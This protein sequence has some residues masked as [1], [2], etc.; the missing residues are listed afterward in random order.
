MQ[1]NRDSK[2]PSLS[3]HSTATPVAKP[4]PL[5][6]PLRGLLDLLMQVSETTGDMQ[7]EVLSRKGLRIASL[8]VSQKQ[9]MFGVSI[10][11]LFFV[12]RL[13]DQIAPAIAAPL[14]LFQ[15]QQ[16]LQPGREEFPRPEF[17][18][19]ERTA[20]LALTARGL[21]GLAGRL[22][23]GPVRVKRSPPSTTI[24]WSA[25]LRFSPMEL[26]LDRP[27]TA[28]LYEDVTYDLF[29]Q[30]PPGTTDSW[31]FVQ[32]NPGQLWP[33]ATVNTGIKSVQDANVACQIA[34][35][36][37]QVLQR[38]SVVLTKERQHSVCITGDGSL[39][40]LVANLN[41]AVLLTL[42]A[43]QLGRVLRIAQQCCSKTTEPESVRTPIT[44]SQPP[45]EPVPA[46]A[47]VSAELTPHPETRVADSEQPSHE[48][49]EQ[50]ADVDQ[51]H[52]EAAHA[53]ETESEQSP[54][55][56][57]RNLQVKADDRTLIKDLTL[58]IPARG[59]YALMGPGGAGKSTLLGVLGGGIAGLQQEGELLYLGQTLTTSHHPV[60]LGQRLDAQE[61]TLIEYVLQRSGPHSVREELHAAE[62]L[63]DSGL[64]RLRA[65]LQRSVRSLGLSASQAW[66]LS[67]LRAL[68]TN[69]ALLCVDEPTAGMENEDAQ[70]ILDLIQHLAAQRAILFVSHNQAHAKSIAQTIALMA[71]ARLHGVLPCAEFFGESAN[72]I[73]REYVRTGGCHVPS[74]DAPLEHIDPDYLAPP[75]ALPVPSPEPEVVQTPP[76]TII[77]WQQDQ[78]VLMLRD[79][80]LTM[81]E[82]CRLSQVNLDLGANG[83]YQLVCPDG[84]IRRLLH[85]FLTTGM[86]GKVSTTGLSLLQG[87]PVDEDHH[88]A[89]IELGVKLLMSSVREYLLS[90]NSQRMSLVSMD[91]K[92]N[93]IHEH[94]E[95]QHALDL[96]EHL[97]G[98]VL[99]L[100][101]EQKRRLAIARA[102][103][104]RP[105]VLCL[106]EPMQGLDQEA[107]ERLSQTILQES[108]RRAVLV[109][110]SAPLSQW[111]KTAQLG[112]IYGEYLYKTPQE[113][114]PQQ[115]EVQVIEATLPVDRSVSPEPHD[116][117][118]RTAGQAAN[119]AFSATEESDPSASELKRDEPNLTSSYGE[120]AEPEVRRYGQGPRGFHWLVPGS[121]AGTPEPGVMHDLEYD[122]ALL[123]GAGITLLVTLTETPLD[124]DALSAQGLKSLFFPIVD[125][126]APSLRA[127]FDLC[128]MIDL[129]L[130]RGEQI[131]FHC[132]AGLGRTGTLLCSYLIWK[133]DSA[134]IA[135]ERARRVEPA[136]VQSKEQEKFL[137]DFEGFCAQQ[138]QSS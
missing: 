58:D 37:V 82:R 117:N 112:Y 67:I 113:E 72:P 42:P 93:W 1:D 60:V 110:V 106:E 50:S 55:L 31:L 85:G 29:H 16:I 102:A 45:V 41:Q 8:P 116:L 21:R 84:T 95:A 48:P 122:L 126:H 28:T 107:T 6:S 22:G 129:Q 79:F 124:D 14:R 7:L 32:H 111:Q 66:R 100:S 130:A 65:S 138:K 3:I 98:Q 86:Q 4:E 68:S 83:L 90:G 133:G 33:V 69:P 27:E 75:A 19:Q 38:Q 104:S 15:Q 121:L 125:M 132:K 73:I 99:E 128:G 25:N 52:R 35:H 13:F 24:G 57:I 56:S 109:L 136:W 2:T 71:A 76:P 53:T 80:G 63:R 88:A 77:L 87:N 17:L 5:P 10:D 70:P 44:P 119:T 94:L 103:A 64:D 54:V 18:E 26:L 40:L 96:E 59:V 20:L 49:I 97:S 134:R 78:P 135:L 137:Q 62:L 43:E 92:H 114:K 47:P 74:P 9:L 39:L 23:A 101:S 115:S 36:L 105:A 30:P 91:D 81:G 131:A 46:S 120:P 118:N 51:P 34:H 12:D 108:A 123:H 61:G 89:T 11:G 127:A